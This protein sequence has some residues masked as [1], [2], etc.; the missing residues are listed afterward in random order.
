MTD[1]LTIRWT[2]V[3]H[4][5]IALA[6][7]SVSPISTAAA[8]ALPEAT[9]GLETITVTAQKR[10]EDS[11]D[12]GISI[13]ALSGKQLEALG[14]SSTGEIPNFV[15]GVQLAQPNGTGSLSFSVRGVTQNDFADHQESP[16]AVYVDDVY[17][18]QMAGAAFQL[19]DIDRVEV[20]RGPQGTLFGRNATG[21]LAHFISRRPTAETDGFLRAT[22][23]EYQLLRTEGALG[24]ALF[25]NENVLGRIAFT[26]NNHEGLFKNTETGG[27]SENG[28]DQAARGQLLFKLPGDSSLLLIARYGNKNVHAG[29]WESRPS[30]PGPDGYGVFGA[31]ENALGYGPSGD[32]Q[33]QGDA[34]GYARI[35]DEGL[36]ARFD[37]PLEVLGGSLFTV[38]ADYQSL[39][40]E[41]LEDSD[42]T[43]LP[44]FHF[45][46]TSD[47]KQYSA[48]TR[49]AG[50][51]G[52]TRWIGG[53]YY[54]SIDGDYTEGAQGIAYGG[55]NSPYTL[56]TESYA[57]FG[58]VDYAITDALGLTAGARYTVDNKDFS[59][60]SFIAGEQVFDFTPGSVGSLSR[61]DDSFWTGKLA[62]NYKLSD[63]SLVY[64]SYNRGIKAGGFNAPLDPTT[65][66]S[67]SFIPFKAE[68]LSSYE[69]G[70]KNEFWG[71][72]ARLN[73]AVFYYDYKDSQALHFIGLTQLI[74]NAP[75]TN[76][77][78]EVE[79]ELVPTADWLLSAG[80][81]YVDATVK[82]V[83]LGLG[84]HDYQPANTPKWSGNA[85]AR[86]TLHTGVGSVAFQFDGN[87]VSSQYFALTNAPVT[88]QSGYG[89]ANARVH[90]KTQNEKV[91]VGLDVNNLLDK[92]YAVMAFDLSDP[93]AGFGLTQ[94]YP[95]K[96]R[97]TT[98]S[99]TYNF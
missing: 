55:L 77:G 75:A 67:N 34:R 88:K 81:S 54:L 13:S 39:Q 63:A 72:R 60:E 68:T 76:F 93:V 87:F 51:A 15:P 36:S 94:L 89:L 31:T 21:G 97:W 56:K 37:T 73:A 28:N 42:T 79:L 47:V 27:K 4:L 44:I 70:S 90:Y 29:A 9:A 1:S 50:E 53:L 86:Y 74:T 46:N 69:I 17:V 14:V 2:A 57:A 83:N 7:V 43:P 41:Y 8:D 65:V 22:V 5:S 40:K 35:R 66:T 18:S 95:G 12:V 48:E 11:Q 92:H 96:P 80:V 49:L 64:V 58:Q 10:V 38:I 84:P 52:K 85:L 59:Y 78:G 20:L 91:D 99:V 71:N 6:A 25:G 3:R 32:F 62:L 16:A 30:S 23:G 82:D 61:L 24:G 19:F 45:F 33:T 98:L 26:T